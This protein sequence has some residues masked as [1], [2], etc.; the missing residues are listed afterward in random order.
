MWRQFLRPGFK[1]LSTWQ[2]LG[3]RVAH[4]CCGLIKP[5]IPD[6]I[7]CGLDIL[8]PFQPDARDMDAAS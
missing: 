2:E 3:Y 6:M 8:N 1:P 7:D 4:H 5:I